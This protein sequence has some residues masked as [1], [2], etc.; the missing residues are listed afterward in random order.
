LAR[1]RFGLFE[2]D[3]ANRELRREGLLVRLQGQPAV[4]LSCLIERAG[5][6]VSREDLRASVWGGETFVDFERGLNFC[7]GQIRSALGDE[8]SEPRYIRTVTRRGYQFIA[9]VEC[10][11]AGL[12]AAGNLQKPYSAKPVWLS[13]GVV[14][15]L[16]AVG[17]G[18]ALRTFAMARRP[19]IVAVVRFDNETG[20]PAITGFSDGVTD[21]VIE[22]ITSWSEGRYQVIGNAKILRVPREQRDLSLIASTLHAKYVVLGQVQNK[23]SDVRILAHLIRLPDQTHLWVARMDRSVA[24]PLQVESETARKVASEFAPRI[25]MDSS[26][27]PLPAAPNR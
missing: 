26:G 8:A 11:G 22:Q 14:V 19:P 21:N 24:D 13:A 17:A 18:Y 6:V 12:V 3:A 5:T 20:D 2:F 9:P 10:V 4:V 7:I 1:Y 15:V 16:L 23:G 27:A 25:A